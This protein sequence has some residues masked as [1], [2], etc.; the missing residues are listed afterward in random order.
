MLNSNHDNNFCY[1]AS[2]DFMYQIAMY[3]LNP[4]NG[5]YNFFKLEINKTKIT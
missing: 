3:N 1:I 5:Y 4:K 2:R